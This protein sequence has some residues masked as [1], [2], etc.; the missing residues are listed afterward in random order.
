S[1]L[2]VDVTPLQLKRRVG[3]VRG[4]SDGLGRGDDGGEDLHHTTDENGDEGE[5]CEGCSLSFELRVERGL[6]FLTRDEEDEEADEKEEAACDD[7]DEA[8]D[9]F[10]EE[11]SGDEADADE[12][13]P[14]L[15]CEEKT[16]SGAIL[17]GCLGFG[18]NGYLDLAIGRLAGARRRDE[19]PGEE[20]ES[21]EVERATDEAHPI[22]RENGDERLNERGVKETTV[23]VLS[24]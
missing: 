9:G 20:D 13:C 21:E 12:C 7:E 5:D 8:L 15:G 6:P 24:A 23:L 1:F 4:R 2:H 3:R 10:E 18:E 22:H 14:D 17:L 19:V 16:H 11:A